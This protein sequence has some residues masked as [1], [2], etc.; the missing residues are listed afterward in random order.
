MVIASYP[1]Q[2]R[3][4]WG[5]YSILCRML[6]TVS[7]FRSV[8]VTD[9]GVLCMAAASAGM[10]HPAPSSNTCFPRSRFTIDGEASQCNITREVH[11]MPSPV[12]SSAGG[13]PKGLSACL[14]G[15]FEKR[16][17]K[18]AVRGRTNVPVYKKRHEISRSF[19]Y[20]AHRSAAQTNKN[21]H[22]L[23]NVHSRRC[24]TFALDLA[25]T[26]CA[27]QKIKPVDNAVLLLFILIL[28]IEFLPVII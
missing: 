22:Q 13:W 3:H 27:P 1:E 26:L 20:N 11:H 8:I 2:P 15:C 17:R 6:S 21:A 5:N 24:G 25:F 10:P 23:L 4:G 28:L 19:Q 7:G 18:G 9:V 16:E 12:V 14:I